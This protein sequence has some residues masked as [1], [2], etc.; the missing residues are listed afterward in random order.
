MVSEVPLDSSGAFCAT[1]VENKGESAIT[2]IAQKNKNARKTN[3]ELLS[4][5]YGDR[6]Q[7]LQDSIKER[8]AIFCAP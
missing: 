5:K 3:C 8:R 2:T 6:M 4:R 7:Q 1:S